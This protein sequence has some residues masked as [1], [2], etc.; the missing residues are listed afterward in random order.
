VAVAWRGAT[1]VRAVRGTGAAQTVSAPGS[2][3]VLSDLAAGPGGR[4]AVVWDGGVD[5]PQS[6]VRAAIAD[7]PG[8]GFG[9]PEDVSDTG[10]EARFG[11][12]AFLGERPAVVLSSRAA[13]GGDSVAR[14][15]VR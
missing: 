3:A 5:D 14:A 1:G 12:A 7:G 8:A 11:H 2:T 9:P 10:Q 4:L 6:V 15:Y 13:G